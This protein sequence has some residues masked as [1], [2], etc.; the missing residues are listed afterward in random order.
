MLVHA[1]N[2][3]LLPRTCHVDEVRKKNYLLLPWHTTRRHGARGFLQD[4]LLVVAVHGSLHVE[5]KGTV[6]LAV[7]TRN[8]LDF[9]G[10]RLTE[11]EAEVAA[12]HAIVGALL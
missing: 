9:L 5:A 2:R 12:Y 11:G 6:A 4:D 1:N 3:D 7:E 10:A 8:G